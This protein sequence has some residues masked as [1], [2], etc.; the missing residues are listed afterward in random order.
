MKTKL[1]LTELS[2][3]ELSNKEMRNINGG[4]I[5]PGCG[6]C[7]CDADVPGQNTTNYN[8]S[9]DKDGF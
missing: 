4:S 1:K 2:R 7:L 3:I 8:K 5:K 9:K 6:D